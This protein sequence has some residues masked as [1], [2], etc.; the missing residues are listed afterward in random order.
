MSLHSFEQP[1]AMPSAPLAVLAG[2]GKLPI[3]VA[4]AARRSG[5]DVLVLGVIG[6]ADDG[7]SA[8][9]HEWVSWGELGKI[10][11]LIDTHGARDL[12]MVGSVKRPDF[13]SLKVDFGTIRALPRIFA[14]LAGGDD[15]ALSGAIKIAE[16]WDLRV[17]GAHEIATDLV[18]GPGTLGLV[19]PTAANREDLT[20]AH[21]AAKAIGELDIGQAAVSIGRHVVAVEGMEGTDGMLLRVRT[22]REE[23]RGR[24][25]D[26][27]GVLAK[28]SKPQ[29]DLRVDMPTVGPKTIE[30]AAA[31]GLAGIGIE[32]GRVMLVDRKEMIALA[33]TAGLFVVAEDLNGTPGSDA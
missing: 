13:R 21:R 26:R 4:D 25:R 19:K 9:R 3:I 8:F 28:R 30:H 33:D 7:I 20:L 22:L 18:A 24:W 6:E 23:G 15:N 1:G 32:A 17:I 27:T 29:Q 10:R 31:A 14:L 5:R 11:K 12:V 16:S 2:G